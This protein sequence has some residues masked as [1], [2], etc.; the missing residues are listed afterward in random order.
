MQL[1][2]KHHSPLMKKFYN[3]EIQLNKLRDTSN[4]I[5]ASKGCLS[6]AVGRRRV[7]AI[8]LR[9]IHYGTLAL[10]CYLAENSRLKLG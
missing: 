4:N 1:S 9:I 10:D 7:T 6:V 5:V 2:T 8:K 3:R